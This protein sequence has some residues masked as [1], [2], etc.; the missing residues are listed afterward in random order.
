MKLRNLAPLVGVLAYVIISIWPR[1]GWASPGVK[2]INEADSIPSK[3][4][5]P[6]IFTVPDD[7]ISI[8]GEYSLVNGPDNFLPHQMC[9]V[10]TKLDLLIQLQECKNQRKGWLKL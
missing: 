4:A 2:Y 6:D 8:V 10:D 7:I 5:V 1:E 9:Q 3:V